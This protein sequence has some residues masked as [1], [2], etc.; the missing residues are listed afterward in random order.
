MK[1]TS[2]IPWPE[3]KFTLNEIHESLARSLSRTSVQLKANAALRDGVI[4]AVGKKESSGAGRP[5]VVFEK[6]SA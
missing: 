3:G 1:N 4:K 6:A 2:Q 5:A